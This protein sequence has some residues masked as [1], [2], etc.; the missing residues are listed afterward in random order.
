MSTFVFGALNATNCS[1]SPRCKSDFDCYNLSRIVNNWAM[2]IVNII[3]SE[4]FVLILDWDVKS[5][6]MSTGRVKSIA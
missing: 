1:L 5:L 6:R 4:I 3:V 2:N